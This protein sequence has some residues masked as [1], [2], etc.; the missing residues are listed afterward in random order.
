T[1]NADTAVDQEKGRPLTRPPLGIPGFVAFPRAEARNRRGRA[2][3]FMS[4]EV[5]AA[6]V[7]ARLGQCSGMTP[8]AVPE[9]Q[10]HAHSLE[11]PSCPSNAL[12]IRR[13]L[14]GLATAPGFSGLASA[15]ARAIAASVSIPAP[16]AFSSA[17]SSA[18]RAS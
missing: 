9:R 15:R 4:D 18:L 17:Y 13:S 12:S 1:P 14:Q 6:R 7:N 16:S 8:D 10:R 2:R 3:D 11:R 5:L